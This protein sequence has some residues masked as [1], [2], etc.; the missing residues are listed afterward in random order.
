MDADYNPDFRPGKHFDFFPAPTPDAVYDMI[1]RRPLKW[2]KYR[3]AIVLTGSSDIYNFPCESLYYKIMSIVHYL[4]IKNHSLKVVVC[5]LLPRPWDDRR[6]FTALIDINLNLE[7]YED[8][9]G[10]FFLPVYV[11]YLMEDNKPD[12]RLYKP[13]F[14]V[15]NKVGAT[16]LIHTF[17]RCYIEL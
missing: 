14:N 15:L 9:Y 16:R 17:R 4:R 12:L 3:V 13:G 6:S 2:H 10:Y 5:G 8:E 1:R 11:D 7:R